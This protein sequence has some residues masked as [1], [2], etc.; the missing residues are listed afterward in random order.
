MELLSA[1]EKQ[2]VV[3]ELKADLKAELIK[4]L[5][6]KD[7]RIANDKSK[8][9]AI[10]REKYRKQLYEKFGIGTWANVW[11]SIRKLSV[12]RTGNI[13]LR[14]LKPSD[15]EEAAVFAENLLIQMGLEEETN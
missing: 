13:Y 1:D 7:L 2:K 3:N 6:G 9:L 5:T 14:D 8:P 4:E 10:V 12:Y 15:E 11:D